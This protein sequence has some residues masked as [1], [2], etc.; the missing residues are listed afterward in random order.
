MKR[1]IV[2]AKERAAIQNI[3]QT[4]GLNQREIAA[5]V[6]YG[7]SSLCN[8]LKGKRSLHPHIALKLHQALGLDEGVAFLEPLYKE[9]IIRDG[10]E[11]LMGNLLVDDAKRSIGVLE[12]SLF[13]AYCV[14]AAEV[15]KA[16]ITGS[17]A[18]KADIL[19][20]LKGL[21]EKYKSPSK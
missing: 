7:A 16:Y 15:C 20:T 18:A 3:A 11:S 13:Q 12:K 21:Y 10:V 17:S 19:D 4:R 6:G 14:H 5:L 2:K 9:I 8:I 1:Y